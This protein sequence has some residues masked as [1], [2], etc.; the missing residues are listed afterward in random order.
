MAILACSSAG[1]VVAVDGIVGWTDE[2][3]ASVGTSFLL[4]E[5][6]S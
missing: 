2:A 1:V 4:I 5:A 6:S 3:I